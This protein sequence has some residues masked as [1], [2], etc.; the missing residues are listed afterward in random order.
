METNKVVDNVATST[1]AMSKKGYH[2]CHYDYFM[3]IDIFYFTGTRKRWAPVQKTL[4]KTYFR[5]HIKSKKVLR[6]RECEDFLNFYRK[7]FEAV[8]KK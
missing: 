2:T 8:S 5:R 4:M 3:I 7:D 6:K 1:N